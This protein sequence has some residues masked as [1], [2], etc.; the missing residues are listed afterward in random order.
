MNVQD[1]VLEHAQK[2]LDRDDVTLDDD[3]FEVGGDSLVGMHFVGRVGR[4]VDLPV[5]MTLLFSYPVL[6]DFAAEVEALRKQAEADGV[7]EA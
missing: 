6:R 7:T 3:F 2:I 4:A 1:T 5:R